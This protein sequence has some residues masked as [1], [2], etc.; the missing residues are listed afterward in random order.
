MIALPMGAE[1]QSHALD[2][3]DLLRRDA[4]HVTRCPM[5]GSQ[6]ELPAQRFPY[7]EM[8]FDL[9]RGVHVLVI[10]PAALGNLTLRENCGLA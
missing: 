10:E 2:A 8:R 4:V 5:H 6:V 1:P 9:G 3:L 7:V